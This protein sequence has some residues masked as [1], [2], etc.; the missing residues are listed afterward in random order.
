MKSKLLLAFLLTLL[1]S[2]PALAQSNDNDMKQDT[3]DAAHSTARATR[4]AGHKIKHGTK[5][6]A[7][8]TARATRRGADK[9]EDKTTDRPSDSNPK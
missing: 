7:H 8:K 9:V 1:L 3:K 4:K 2:L 6:A 5:K